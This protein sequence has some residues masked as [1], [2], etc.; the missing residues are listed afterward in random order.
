MDE[1]LDALDNEENDLI[2]GEGGG[3]KALTSL[4]AQKK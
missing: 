1:E 2:V 4:R 3:G